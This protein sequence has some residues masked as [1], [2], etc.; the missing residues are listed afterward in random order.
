MW[1]RKWNALLER[2]SSSFFSPL[3]HCA[4]D[5]IEVERSVFGRTISSWAEG[6][7]IR[8]NPTQ[9]KVLIALADLSNV[10]LNNNIK[11][12]RRNPEDVSSRIR[13]ENQRALK[14]QHQTSGSVYVGS[15]NNQR[16]NFE[17]SDFCK[18]ELNGSVTNSTLQNYT[19]LGN[20]KNERSSIASECCFPN[21]IVKKR[22]RRTF[23]YDRFEEGCSEPEEIV[24]YIFRI[25]EYFLPSPIGPIKHSK[26]YRLRRRLILQS[27]SDLILIKRESWKSVDFTISK[28]N[29]FIVHFREKRYLDNVLYFLQN[30]T[31]KKEFTTVKNQSFIQNFLQ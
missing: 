7:A 14:K 18:A 6:G 21:H 9:N 31:N 22:R 29:L 3:P 8:H 15:Q 19:E 17:V 12:N 23:V 24:E 4:E 28:R 2:I 5:E 30:W 16:R 11:Q 27:V 20:V 26:V 10:M 13:L 25:E 1:D